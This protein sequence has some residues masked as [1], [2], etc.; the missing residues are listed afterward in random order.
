M[1]G[2]GHDVDRCGG[3]DKGEEIFGK[4]VNVCCIAVMFCMLGNMVTI[5]KV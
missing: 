3:V 4:R 1:Q 2:T 5:Q